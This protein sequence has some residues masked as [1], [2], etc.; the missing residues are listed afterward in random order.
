LETFVFLFLDKIPYLTILL[1]IR[2]QGT[3]L[4]STSY[5]FKFTYSIGSRKIKK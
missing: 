3:Q 5:I 4:A 2:Y 1:M